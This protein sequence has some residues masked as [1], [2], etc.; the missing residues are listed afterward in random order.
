MVSSSDGCCGA[1]R[2]SY[3]IVSTITPAKFHA[4]EHSVR[5][6]LSGGEPPIGIKP[7]TYALR[8]CSRALLA[9]PKPA[10]T[11]CSQVTVGGG[12]WLLM[13]I[14]GHVPVL[15]GPVARWRYEQAPSYGGDGAC[16]A[17]RLP[18]LAAAG[19]IPALGAFDRLA[20]DID[21]LDRVARR[22]PV[23]AEHRAGVRPRS[24]RSVTWD[25]FLPA[26][27]PRPDS[28]NVVRPGGSQACTFTAPG[29]ASAIYRICPACLLGLDCSSL[30]RLRSLR[31]YSGLSV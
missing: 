21:V 15:R 12:H 8:G 26:V 16:V 27:H 1:R 11:S 31:V 24:D 4:D 25:A 2:G 13:A 5:F 3:G 20:I 29:A 7:M 10:L 30:G 28:L 6:M 17:G 23:T 9:G 18:E 14:R 22:P 19:R